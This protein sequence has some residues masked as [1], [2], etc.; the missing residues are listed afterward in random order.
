[1]FLKFSFKS[2]LIAAA[3]SAF[4]AVSFAQTAPV[5]GEVK[6]KKADG[7]IVPAA[8]VTVDAYR[9][10]IDKGK[11]P[12]A[13]TNKKGEFSFVGFILGQTYALVVSGPGISPELRPSVKAG[14][15]N[16][17][18]EVSEG[19]GKQ[20]T[21]DQVRTALKSA[22]STQTN[23]GQMTAEQK[24]AQAD[25][26]QKK[27]EYET[28]KKKA[29]DANKVVNTAFQEGD[30][31]YKAKD[32]NGAIAKFDEGI[33]ADPEFEGSAPILLN[34]KAVALKDR[35]FDSYK[36]SMS[37]DD[38]AKAAGM[39]KAKADFLAATAALDKAL[40]ILKNAPASTDPA[41]QKGAE[42]SKHNILANYVEVYRILVKTRADVTKAKDVGPIYEQYLAVET[43]PAKKATARI[44]LGD[45]MQEAGETQAALD[46]YMAVLQDSP[47]NVDAL[48][49]AGFSLVNLGYLNNDKTK[50]Q[51]A[52]N[53]L[54][55]FIAAAPDTNKYKADAVSLIDTLKKEQ[56]VTPQKGAPAPKKK[57]Q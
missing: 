12:A 1:M 27:A 23:T 17:S 41:A 42:T 33:N 39:E 45:I 29:E 51:E 10:D 40:L 34:Y 13:K 2:I 3:F 11:M 4:A 31:L 49:G 52:V 5:S 56:N 32:Y 20:W 44:N 15:D 18:I 14:T 16:I 28:Q 9:T 43:D 54:Q 22:S 48:A 46:A 38:A 8:G 47:D 19:D 30:K 53:Y 57:G 26:E 7:T 55:R 6:L 50:F 25:Y 37:G 35:G 21:E 36:Q 24:K